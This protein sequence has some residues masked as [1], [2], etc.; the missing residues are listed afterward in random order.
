MLDQHALAE[1]IIFEKLTK[2]DFAKNSQKLLIQESLTLTPKEE[3]ILENY[4]EIFLD[5]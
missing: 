1:R 2:K 5:M 4:K 3:S